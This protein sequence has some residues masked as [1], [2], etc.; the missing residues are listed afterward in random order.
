MYHN[1]IFV[2][3]YN[4]L[5]GLM[6]IIPGIDVGVAVIIFTVIIR[7]ILFPLSKKS[8]LTQV[9][10][11]E[12]EPEINKIKKDYANDRQV[13]GVKIM[14]F[15]KAKGIKPFNGI[16]PVLIQ[17]PV[18]LALISVFYK[19]IPTIDPTLLY[20]FV[21]VPVIKPTLFGLSLV[22]KSLIL[23]LITGVVQFL[24]LHY[25]VAA[26]QQRKMVQSGQISANQNDLSA[27]LANSMTGQMKFFLPLLAFASVY[28]IIPA[29]FP[30][31]SAIIAI[32]W[33][34]STLFTLFQELVVKRKYLL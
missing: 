26:S 5:I 33:S 4:G 27:H 23:S 17:L 9:K 12:V 22:N 21:H 3:L 25:S 14:E 8:L 11:K 13:Q 28:W 2:P 1:Y 20:N 31:A 19:I 10:M 24:Q 30:Q 34:V 16:L 18:M 15:Y 29:K 6:D 7:L 32:Y